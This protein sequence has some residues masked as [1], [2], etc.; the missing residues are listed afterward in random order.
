MC[1]SNPWGE[2]CCCCCWISSCC[3]DGVFLLA[4]WMMLCAMS[5]GAG[6]FLP[7]LSS[8]SLSLV[9]SSSS[10]LTV[11]SLLD[12]VRM[13]TCSSLLADVAGR[14]CVR[15]WAVGSLCST[16]LEGSSLLVSSL[17]SSLMAGGLERIGEGGR[18]WWVS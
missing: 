1:T 11:S 16:L 18:I 5:S 8:L 7:A 10:L 3:R 17:L 9:T 6:R 2:S 4:C 13:T 12:G 15:S 14:G